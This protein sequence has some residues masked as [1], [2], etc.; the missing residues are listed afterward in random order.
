MTD[1]SSRGLRC[2]GRR[3]VSARG[4]FSNDRARVLMSCA[5]NK[6]FVLASGSRCRLGRNR[7]LRLLLQLI[8][9]NQYTL[10]VRR[11]RSPGGEMSFGVSGDDVVQSTAAL[12]ALNVASR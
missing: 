9:M 2:R 7:G 6:L 12:I 5:A 10:A 3:R 11:P 4:S 8:M 1:G